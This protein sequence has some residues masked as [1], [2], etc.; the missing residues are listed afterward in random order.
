MENNV[1]IYPHRRTVNDLC[2]SRVKEKDRLI[3]EQV[4]EVTN[5]NKEIARLKEELEN[6]RDKNNVSIFLCSYF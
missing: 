2:Y 4:S 5:L 3:E 6:Q 1:L